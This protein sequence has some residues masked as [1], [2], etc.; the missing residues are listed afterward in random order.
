MKPIVWKT[1]T[2]RYSSG[3]HA[4]LG[5]VLVAYVFYNSCRVRD[6]PKVY[7]ASFE[8]PS[9]SPQSFETEAEAIQYAENKI[10]AWFK[11][12]Q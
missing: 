9:I 6:D 4:Y 8:L 11:E 5:R 7:K 3:K 12:T 2:G 10:A 1:S